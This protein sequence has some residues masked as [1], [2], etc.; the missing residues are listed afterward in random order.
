MGVKLSA[1]NRY[2][3][4]HKIVWEN[5]LMTFKKKSDAHSVV[6]SSSRDRKDSSKS[7]TEKL[8]GLNLII[9]TS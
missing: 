7:L 3:V 6:S 2:N 9:K 8:G 4:E 5:K 1:I